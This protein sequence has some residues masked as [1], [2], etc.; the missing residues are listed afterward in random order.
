M[1]EI[2]YSSTIIF[3]FSRVYFI[4]AYL[5]VNGTIGFVG[6]LTSCVHWEERVFHI[7]FIACG[8]FLRKIDHNHDQYATSNRQV[9]PCIGPKCS[10]P[11][12]QILIN[13]K[14][15]RSV[16]CRRPKKDGWGWK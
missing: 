4:P 6:G 14:K 16:L 10:I 1:E 5:N 12:T 11:E 2:L 13:Q 7:N 9:Q 8:I 15:E 3:A